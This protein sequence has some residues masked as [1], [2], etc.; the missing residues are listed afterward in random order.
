MVSSM[1]AEPRN[2]PSTMNWTNQDWKAATYHEIVVH[3]ACNCQ[4]SMRKNRLD[5]ATTE[6]LVVNNMLEELMVVAPDVASQP[7]FQLHSQGPHRLPLTQVPGRGSYY[8]W[9]PEY[10][11][12]PQRYKDEDC[13]GSG[14]HR[15]HMC[16]V[17]IQEV[18]YFGSLHGLDIGLGYLGS[19]RASDIGLEHLDSPNGSHVGLLLHSENSECHMVLAAALCCPQHAHLC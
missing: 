10:F 2:L 6:Q 12:E 17:H 4:N 8:S 11:D 1:S 18:G 7:D 14:S 13:M 16:S 9:E 19:L 5:L 3:R 15:N